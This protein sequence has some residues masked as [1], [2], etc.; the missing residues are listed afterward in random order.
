MEKSKPEDVKL[1]NEARGEALGKNVINVENKYLFKCPLNT[2]ILS[3]SNEKDFA[4]YLVEKEYAERIDAWI[5]SVDKGFYTVPYSFRAGTPSVSEERG[6]HQK[7]ASFNPDFFIKVGKHIL[8]VEIKSDEDIT[9]V[10]KG[11][12]RWAKKHFEEIN[13]DQKNQ[14]YHFYFLS[15]ADFSTFF[16]KVVKQREF[17]YTS[18]L[19]AELLG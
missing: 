15:P 10:N 17:D 5:K 14:I 1:I 19:E 11:K 13:K 18:N 4:G 8:V 12:L 6:S 3:H 16:E 9:E 7:W 2:V